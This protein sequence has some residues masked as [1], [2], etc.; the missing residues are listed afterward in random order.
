MEDPLAALSNRGHYSLDLHR[1]VPIG[2]RSHGAGIGAE[3][4]GVS[5]GPEFLS[6]EVPQ[7]VFAAGKHLGRRRVP[8]VRIVS[9]NDRFGF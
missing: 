4:D 5:E 9:P 3:S 7:I 8:D 1:S 2:R 6:A